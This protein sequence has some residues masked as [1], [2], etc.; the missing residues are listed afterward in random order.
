MNNKINKSVLISYGG[1][2]ISYGIIYS[3]RKTMEIAVKPDCSVLVRA[4][5]HT[6][7]DF[8]EKRLQKRA[9]WILR[10]IQHF[11]RFQPLTPERCY[12]NGET[13]LYLG[14]QYRLKIVK[15]DENAVCLSRGIFRVTTKNEPSPAIV[16]KLLQDWYAKK[17]AEIFTESLERYWPH[18]SK[19][20]VVKPQLRLRRM[21]RRWGSMS[22]RGIMTLNTELIKAPKECIDYVVIHEL[23]HL[24][25]RN[26][27]PGFYR[28]LALIIPDWEKKKQKLELCL[29]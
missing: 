14:R 18:F 6:E 10:Q 16:K 27:G 15:G 17:A 5:F 29:V 21:K 20:K 26:H 8:I 2:E 1:A 7:A 12:V 23:C 19:F 3:A 22:G 28:L 13:H 25:H 11:E 4:P 9:V 24:I